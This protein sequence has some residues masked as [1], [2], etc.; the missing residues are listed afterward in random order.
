MR[1][2]PLRLG[3]GEGI[4]WSTWAWEASEAVGSGAGVE[5]STWAW[6]ASEAVGSGADV[7]SS[8]IGLGREK[9]R[10]RCSVPSCVSCGL[11]NVCEVATSKN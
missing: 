5:A 8:V 1:S 3:M 9:H 4:C 2:I 6:E 7:E 10:R 11:T